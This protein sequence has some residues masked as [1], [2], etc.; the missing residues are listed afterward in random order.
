MVFFGKKKECRVIE[1]D[2]WDYAGER[3]PENALERVEKHLRVCASCR[4]ET[5]ALRRAQHLLTDCRRQIPAPRSGWSDLQYRMEREGMISP[6]SG[7]I[8][9]GTPTDATDTKSQTRRFRLALDANRLSLAG[10][11]V[12]TLVLSVAVYRLATPPTPD[13]SPAPMQAEAVP[14]ESPQTETP[15][16]R[17]G[18][19]EQTASAPASNGGF[20]SG[21][22]SFSPFIGYGFIPVGNTDVPESKPEPRRPITQRI[23]AQPDQS[24]ADESPIVWGRRKFRPLPAPTKLVT[25]EDKAQN[26]SATDLNQSLTPNTDA[27][28]DAAHSKNSPTRLIMPSLTPVRFTEDEKSF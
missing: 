1:H 6:L 17:T 26:K 12:A 14:I 3:L 20:V 11:M 7:R 23:A 5:E 4:Q 25:Q 22:G 13:F 2:L 24:K 15:V 19:S 10:S 21:G 9:V 16:P 8:L 18:S 28:R 27:R